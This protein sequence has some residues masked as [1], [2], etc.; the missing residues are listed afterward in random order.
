MTP[1]PIGLRK[2]RET[3]GP[4]R[5]S[6]TIA[7]PPMSVDSAP[8]TA[9]SPRSARTIRSR[10]SWAAMLRWSTAYCSLTRRVNAFSVSAMNGTS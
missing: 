2:A 7:G 8:T 10:R 1:S 4:P 9:S 5:A 6:N 3:T